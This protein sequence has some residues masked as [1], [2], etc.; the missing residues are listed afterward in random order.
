[1]IEQGRGFGI[2]PFQPAEGKT[3]I[4]VSPPS[5]PPDP[6][7][8]SG[9]GLS[10]NP[11]VVPNWP[12][13]PLWENYIRK[14]QKVGHY[15]FLNVLGQCQGL[16]WAEWVRSGQLS[17]ISGWT[18]VIKKQAR[19]RSRRNGVRTPLPLTEL[20]LWKPLHWYTHAGEPRLTY[21]DQLAVDVGLQVKDLKNVVGDRVVW[22]ERVDLVRAIRPH[23]ADNGEETN[24]Q[25]AH[26]RLQRTIINYPRQLK[27][28]K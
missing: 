10:R 13:I 1:M 18:W 9:Q 2:G 24:S 20:K 25:K 17:H 14:G 16:R 19:Q 3:H 5:L 15:C 6:T 27:K 7:A 11:A 22:K 26:T 28:E 4:T 12:S 23:S 21:T 8:S